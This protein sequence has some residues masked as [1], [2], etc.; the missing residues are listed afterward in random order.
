MTYKAL[1][2]FC[3]LGG[4][5]DGLAAAGFDV[6]GIDIVKLPYKHKF[7]LADIMDLNP[8]NFR[9]YD[10]I[11]GSPPCRNFTKLVSL[12][13]RWKEP[14]DINKGLKLVHAFLTFVDIAKPKIWIMENV[15]GLE[16]HLSIKHRLRT[17]LTPTMIRL[18]WGNFPRFLIYVENRKPADKIKGKHRSNLR[19]KIP[20]HTALSFGNACIEKLKQ[21]AT[22]VPSESC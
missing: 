19:A 22:S 14:L 11:V 9:G 1:D 10:V 16:K 18:F 4:W 12:H 13:K 8:Q 15:P 3:G 2:V 17:H 5:S 21:P 7:I 6:K 20:F